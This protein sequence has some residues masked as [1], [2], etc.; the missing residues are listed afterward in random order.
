VSALFIEALSV[1]HLLFVI[2]AAAL[3]AIANDK[4]SMLNVR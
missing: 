1:E 4:S 3:P 2:A